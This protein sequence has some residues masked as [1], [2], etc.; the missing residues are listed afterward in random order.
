MQTPC[1]KNDTFVAF[2]AYRLSPYN[3][4]NT[5]VPY[6]KVF[7]NSGNALDIQTGEF[8][9]PVKGIYS[10]YFSGLKQFASSEITVGFLHNNRIVTSRHARLHANGIVGPGNNWLPID[11]TVIL[12]LEKGDTVGVLLGFGGL[13]DSDEKD[14]LYSRG[15]SF[16][17]YLIQ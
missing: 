9:A 4:V 13:H 12:P 11:M 15:T 3:K 16:I 5:T 6:E 1:P 17:G 2:H 8:K 10:F 7:L 14:E